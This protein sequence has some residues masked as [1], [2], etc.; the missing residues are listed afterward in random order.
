MGISFD[1]YSPNSS[2]AYDDK[3]EC[4]EIELNPEWKQWTFLGVL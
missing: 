2:I 3:I 1:L 4:I